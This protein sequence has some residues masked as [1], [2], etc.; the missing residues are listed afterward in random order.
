MGEVVPAA[1]EEIR[2]VG[3]RGPKA[4]RGQGNQLARR[5]RGAD[6]FRQL[7]E[8]RKH[9]A[10]GPGRGEP[11][12]GYYRWQRK[13]VVAGQPAGKLA[14][15]GAETDEPHQLVRGDQAVSSA[16]VFPPSSSS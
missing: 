2:R 8:E 9:A 4:G 6:R 7:R 1:G 11:E 13:D 14:P 12:A 16:T 15:A 5:D 10:D 3:D